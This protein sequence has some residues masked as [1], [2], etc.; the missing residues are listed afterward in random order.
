MAGTHSAACV[1]AAAADDDA[2]ADAASSLKLALLSCLTMVDPTMRARLK[3][4]TPEEEEAASRLWLRWW[5]AWS[6]SLVKVF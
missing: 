2:D 1:D 4:L 6:S 5:W 3:V